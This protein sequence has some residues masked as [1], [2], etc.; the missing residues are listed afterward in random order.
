MIFLYTIVL[1]LLAALKFLIDRRASMLAR[2][3][4]RVAG[5]VDQMLHEP[6]FKEGNSG[7][8]NPCALAQRQFL[9]GSLVYKKERLEARYSRW[10]S[11]AD[12]LTRTIERLRNWKGKKLPY[13][14]GA[15]DVW[16]G[17]YLLDYL[18]MGQYLSARQVIQVVAAW[19]GV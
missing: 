13:T 7:R 17:L 10:Q 2:R 19:L 15:L 4:S 12:R 16:L 18:G 3:Y 1:M 8:F 5:T 14:L 9:L 6:I 11:A